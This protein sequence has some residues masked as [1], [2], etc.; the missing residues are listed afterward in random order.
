M[1]F[2]FLSMMLF[3][4]LSMCLFSCSKNEETSLDK[5][6]TNVDNSLWRAAHNGGIFGLS[7]NQGYYSL[8]YDYGGTYGSVS[9]TYTQNGTQIK[10]Q[11]KIFPTYTLHKLKTG[12]ISYAGSK[13][14]VPVYDSEG[15]DF[16]L[17]F[18]HVIK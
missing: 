11:E 7:F 3:L 13:M 17:S 2:K 1:K 4:A 8:T 10:F 15:L 16:T 5:V 12:Q 9:G 14:S 6:L 18:I